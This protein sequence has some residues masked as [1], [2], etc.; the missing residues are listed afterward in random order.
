MAVKQYDR[1]KSN[2]ALIF[3]SKIV[4]YL[5]KLKLNTVQ[6]AFRQNRLLQAML[7]A[8]LCYSRLASKTQYMPLD[9]TATC[10]N[11]YFHTMPAWDCTL[12]K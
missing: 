6:Q 1:K 8:G 11:H 2:W 9:G 12:I 10:S 3:F 7:R 4:I 5:S